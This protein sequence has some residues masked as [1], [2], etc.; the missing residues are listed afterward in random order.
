MET[1][2]PEDGKQRRY[3]EDIA[4]GL[5]RVFDAKGT[6]TLDVELDGL[7]WI[8]MSDHHKG[9]RDGADDFRRCERVYNAALASYLEEG[10]TLAAL[11]DAEELWECS[12]SEVL[13]AYRHTLEL[14]AE[15]HGQGRYERFWGNH[16][17]AWRHAADVKKHL[18]RA[19][20]PGLRVREALKVR[21]NRG[22]AALGS[23][24]LVHGHQG[25]AESD[26]F[27]WF[28]RLV[29]RH[30]WRPL[31]R[32]LD[33]PSTTPARDWA[34]RARHEAA[35]FAWAR[36]RPEHPV[37]IAGHTHRPVFGASMP[38]P[39]TARSADDIRRELEALRASPPVDTERA[40]A[41]RAELEFVIA[42]QRRVERPIPIEP[43]CFFN[44]GCCSFGDGDITGIELADGEI[45]L[46]RWSASEGA[47]SRRV[48]AYDSLAHTFARVAGGVATPS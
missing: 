34:L 25:T 32:K 7:R 12:P 37:L 43:P 36:G 45:R 10:Y 47:P 48:L 35:M 46:V 39:K 14:E 4:K 44:T 1:M 16:D 19:G 31:Q 13:D 17:D 21:V 24:F 29:V 33:V 15:F 5:S 28:S 30:V 6:D 40:A 27:G 23:L 26:R 18:Q 22:G 20:F 42:E 9:A 2:A 11:G 3:R 8:V 41:L 38:E